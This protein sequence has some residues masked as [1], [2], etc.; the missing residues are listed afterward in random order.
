MI[1]QSE[2]NEKAPGEAHPA[3]PL[4]RPAVERADAR[5][6][7][8]D[9]VAQPR[10]IREALTLLNGVDLPRG[11]F[12]GGLV[13]CGVGGSGLAG[14]IT[15]AIVG[16]RARRPI[17]TVRG[18]LPDPWVGPGTFVFCPSYSGNTDITLEYFAAAH[19]AG[20]TVVPLT[21][22]GRLVEMAA[23]R[24]LPLVRVPA[25]FQPRALTSYAIVTA[26]CC[27]A[28]ADVAP[29]LRG[30]VAEAADFLDGL[31]QAWGP[32]SPA[33]SLAKSLA[34]AF[35]DKGVMIYGSGPTTAAAHRWK[36]QLNETG[37]RLAFS[38]ELLEADHHELC[39]WGHLNEPGSWSA[40]FLEDRA[41]Q[42]PAAVRRMELTAELIA[43][44]GGSTHWISAQGETRTQR[45]LS[46]VLLADFVSVY[47]AAL[48]GVDPSEIELIAELNR[49]VG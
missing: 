16:P 5:L 27:A 33:D 30:E 11:D 46:L 1:G 41:D 29:D 45:M 21:S 39:V 48:S 19:T 24:D 37:K 18:Y 22:G 47:T 9:V 32:E 38:S 4:A 14:D 42:H 35:H 36:T 34:H 28:A 44:A 23:E 31:V 43:G 10:H 8:N 3:D 49:L 7:I 17:Q 13:I 20:A 15:A 12:P 25:G 26:L 6:M 2:T 40:L